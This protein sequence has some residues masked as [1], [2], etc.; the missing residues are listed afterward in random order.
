METSPLVSL[1][2]VNLCFDLGNLAVLIRVTNVHCLVEGDVCARHD[3]AFM[4]VN[5]RHIHFRSALAFRVFGRL[6][7]E[8]LVE[9]AT[10]GLVF[11]L[12]SAALYI[13]HHRGF[14][15]DAAAKRKQRDQPN[16]R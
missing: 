2:R 9:D 14:V 15:T 10:G 1:V 11:E 4:F 13:L 8:R 12:D 3:M 6:F 16:E 5:D 7:A